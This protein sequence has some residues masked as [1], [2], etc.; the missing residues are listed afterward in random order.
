MKMRQDLKFEHLAIS[1]LVLGFILISAAA[2]HGLWW[3]TTTEPRRS[4][5]RGAGSFASP[6]DK[7]WDATTAKKVK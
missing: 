3:R 4:C 6:P 1:G 5:W 7:S 2:V